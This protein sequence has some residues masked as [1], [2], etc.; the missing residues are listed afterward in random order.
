MS[1]NSKFSV[2]LIVIIA[3]ITLFQTVET[4]AAWGDFDTSFGFQG[5]AIDTI[6]NHFPRK[7]AIQPD[8]KILVTG[9][10]ITVFGG[11]GFF[12]RRY[13]SNGQLDTAFGSNG[14][15]TSPEVNNF[16]SDYVGENIVVQ[17]DGKIA[18]SGKANGYYAVW[19]F[20]INGK[21]DR[22]FG[23]GGLQILTSYPVINN[24]FSE[25]NIQSGKLL[26]S[27]RK[28]IGGSYRFVLLRLNSSGTIDGTF[29]NAG[30]SLTGIRG[31]NASGTVIETNG[32]ITVSGVKLD[33]S[34]AKGLERKL[35]NG[36]TDLTFFPTPSNSIGTLESGL[37]K[38]ANGKYALRTNNLAGNGSSTLV[39]DK[40]SSTGIFESSVSPFNGFSVTGCPE[41]FANQTDGK[42]LLQ[43]AGILFRLNTELDFS[44]METNYCSN[45]SGMTN[46]ARAAIQPDDKMVV[47]GIYN[48]NLI[49]VRLLPN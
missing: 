1:N 46:F 18:V 4:K 3:L 13:L 24:T 7:V 43:F 17:A 37:V 34:S 21:K 28:V 10:K 33:D 19:Q 16:N 32:K 12:L 15:A 27:L 29:G 6:N 9:D 44:T 2:S 31:F 42:V 11:K 41:V 35:S 30:E 20:D 40:F 36:Q 25:I 26:L 14:A 38:M 39:L 48:G 8:G 45:L 49:L 5:L 22:T 23:Q 47:A